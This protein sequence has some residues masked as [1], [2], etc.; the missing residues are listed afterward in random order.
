MDSNQLQ[1]EEVLNLF[2]LHGTEEESEDERMEWL[3]EGEWVEK[4]SPAFGSP[5]LLVFS[6]EHPGCPCG[7]FPCREP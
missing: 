3:V 1:P 2:Q 4:P 6:K 5:P 7:C